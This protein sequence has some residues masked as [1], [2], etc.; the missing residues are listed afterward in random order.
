MSKATTGNSKYLHGIIFGDHTLKKN[1]HELHC[2]TPTDPENHLVPR[3]KGFL[4]SV[5]DPI[6]QL[7]W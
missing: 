3:F 6:V 7:S 4:S 5:L 2:P 1:A